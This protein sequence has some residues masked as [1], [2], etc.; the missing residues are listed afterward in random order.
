MLQ[1]LTKSSVKNQYIAPTNTALDANGDG[2]VSPLDA[3]LVLN[4]LQARSTSG[5]PA[6]NSH[7]DMNGDGQVTPVDALLIMNFLNNRQATASGAEGER[8]KRA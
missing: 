4:A 6:D 1:V 8:V 7:L 2:V 3:L 5:L